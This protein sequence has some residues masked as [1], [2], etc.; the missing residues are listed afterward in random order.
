MHLEAMTKLGDD[1]IAPDLGQLQ[2]ELAG[3]VPAGSLRSLLG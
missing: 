1:G 3:A 2:G